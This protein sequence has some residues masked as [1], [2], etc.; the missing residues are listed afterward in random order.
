[1]DDSSDRILESL[2]QINVNLE[3]LRVTL[4]G[5]CERAGDHET[6]LREIEVWKHRLSPL[7]ACMSFIAGGITNVLMG[8][9]WK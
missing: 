6:R 1:M 8:Q 3:G 2:C 4:S 7:V 5:V 9:F